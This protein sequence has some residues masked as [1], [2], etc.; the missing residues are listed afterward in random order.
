MPA[1]ITHDISW[2]L[3]SIAATRAVEHAAAAQLAPHTLMQ[4]AGLATAQLA[5]ALAPHAQTI[6]VACG[7]GNNG[8]DGLQAALHLQRW[9]H[10]PVVTLCGDP[11]LL[12]LDAAAALAQARAAGIVIAADPPAQCDLAIDALLPRSGRGRDC[13]HGSHCRRTA[14]PSRDARHRCRQSR[15]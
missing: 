2:P 6:W 11:A 9:G 12:P 14:S 8:G 7:P 13:I 3:H 5:C 15:C 10:R 4:R 1:A